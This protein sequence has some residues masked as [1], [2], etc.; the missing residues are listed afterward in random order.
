MAVSKASYSHTA[1]TTWNGF[2]YQ[3]KVAIYH[4]L[5]ILKQQG[6]PSTLVLQLDGLEDFAILD[7]NGSVISMHQV[8]ALKSTYYSAYQ[9]A[10]EQLKSKATAEGCAEAFFMLLNK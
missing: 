5:R 1:I 7:E 10:F 2:V 8:K 9:D 6:M 4:V 3:G